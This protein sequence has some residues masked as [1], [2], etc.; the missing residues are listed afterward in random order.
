MC[1][2]LGLRRSAYYK[3][4]NRPIPENEQED[5]KLSET[6]MDYYQKYGGIL[7]YRRMCIFINRDH[8]KHYNA[9]RIHRIMKIMD[10]HSSIRRKRT[11]CT[12]TNKT[13]QTAEN[14]LH[15][16][17]EASKPNEEWT[18]DVTEF[19]VPHSTPSFQNKLKEQ[20]MVQSMSRVACCLD[21]GP[22][23]GLW[24]IIKTEM[25]KMYEIHNKEDLIEA[26]RK[27][28]EFYNDYR[29]QSRFDSKT[30]MEV[31]KEAID[32]EK[33]KHYPIVFNPKIAK[34]KETLKN[35]A[36]SA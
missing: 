27:Y 15:R 18:T 30:P 36:Q 13:D 23:E 32:K 6:V 11:C 29:Y 10:I 31:R 1:K 21:N 20:G 16:E 2:R 33:P 19:K 4:L 9:K 17:F 34:Y 26:I 14:I 24:G 28:I 35:K 22:T 7:G 8:N 25:D 3:W 12:V 5:M